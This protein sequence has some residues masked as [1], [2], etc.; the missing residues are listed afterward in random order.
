MTSGVYSSLYGE[1][2]QHS[3]KFHD[4]LRMSIPSF[5]ELLRRLSTR[6][7]RQDTHLRRSVTP[8][9]RLVVTLRYLATGESF[10]SMHFQLHLGKSTISYIVRDTCQALWDLLREEFLPHPS[11]EQWKDIAENFWE[12]TRFPNCVGAVDGKHIRI[13]KP[14]R[15]GSL[16]YNYKEYFSI[17][18]MAIADAQY[19]FL[20]VDI[21][22]YDHTNESRIFKDSDMGR[23]IYSEN[24][25]LPAPK[26]FPGTDGPPMPFVVVGNEAFQMC[27][28]LLK[29][30]SNR[31][32]NFQ[33]RIYSYRLSRAWRRVEC[34][35]GIL[36]AKWRIFTT[37]IQLK[38]ESV[39]DIVKA[40][41]V[42]HNFLLTREPLPVDTEELESGLHGL[43]SSGPRS[44]VAVRRM[45]DNFAVF[46]LSNAGWVD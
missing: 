26:P 32:L 6:L 38:P 37:T 19:R 9:E 3:E 1:L 17:V 44:T 39:D 43:D 36:T 22:A 15:S 30:Y 5:D 33:K 16:F 40:C 35:F 29:P 21:G 31:G 13:Q 12:V 25:G 10:S 4:Y 8:E 46:I 34:A 2:R 14:A 45:R 11:I 28:N 7:Q 42:L 20:A 27:G 18:L 24:F 23:R 41:V